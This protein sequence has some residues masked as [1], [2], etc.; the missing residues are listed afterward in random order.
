MMLL[1]SAYGAANLL[2]S[3][4]VVSSER[5]PAEPPPISYPSICAPRLQCDVTNCVFP[6]PGGRRFY[7][8]TSR[9]NETRGDVGH[10][11]GDRSKASLCS[12]FWLLFE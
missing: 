3:R 9:H 1:Y 2:I 5:M 11:V 6:S 4:Y 7:R 12:V 8:L 10:H